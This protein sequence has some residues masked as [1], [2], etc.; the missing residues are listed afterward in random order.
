MNWQIDVTS[1]LVQS[2]LLKTF[3]VVLLLGFACSARWLAAGYE[4]R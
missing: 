4:T 3:Q 1:F 2:E